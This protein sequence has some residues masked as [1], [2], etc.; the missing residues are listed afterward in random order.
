MPRLSS[1]KECSATS[2]VEHSVQA[3]DLRAPDSPPPVTS[4]I[5]AGPSDYFWAHVRVS[6]HDGVGE[7][8]SLLLPPREHSPPFFIVVAKQD[9][10]EVDPKAIQ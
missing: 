10:R 3:A 2:V 8:L 5:V 6:A 1:G 9:V 4:L 7:P